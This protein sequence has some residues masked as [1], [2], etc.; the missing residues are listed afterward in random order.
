MLAPPDVI[1][2]N[3]PVLNVPP[4]VLTVI[5]RAEV[6]APPAT[7]V[8]LASETPPLPAPSALSA[9]ATTV[10]PLMAVPPEYWFGAESTSVPVPDLV[11]DPAP[12]IPLVPSWSVSV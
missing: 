7:N 4:P 2:L 1:E 5:V 6:S 9:D 12:P 3:P 11:S 10:P 8:A